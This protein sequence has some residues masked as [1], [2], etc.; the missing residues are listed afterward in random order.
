MSDAKKQHDEGKQENK[1]LRKKREEQRE[2]KEH[3]EHEHKNEQLGTNPKDD[4]EENEN[5][6][7]PQ[8]GSVFNIGDPIDTRV[9]RQKQKKDK[10]YRR[11]ISGKRVPTLS[12]R[13][14]GKYVRHGFPKGEIKDV[15]LDATIKHELSVYM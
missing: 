12:L 4:H 8:K 14:N 7:E 13:N 1:Q 9:V 6:K 3:R 11:K 10:T 2:K 5:V 15:A